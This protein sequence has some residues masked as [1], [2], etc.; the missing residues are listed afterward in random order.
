MGGS[1]NE[2]TVSEVKDVELEGDDAD[3]ARGG[4]DNDDELNRCEGKFCK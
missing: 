4:D 1:I 3:S 2:L